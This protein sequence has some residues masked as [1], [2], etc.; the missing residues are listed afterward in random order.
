MDGEGTANLE[1]VVREGLLEFVTIKNYNEEVNCTNNWGKRIS[2][3]EN[4]HS[5][6]HH[7]FHMQ[8]ISRA[9]QCSR[10][11]GYCDKQDEFPISKIISHWNANKQGEHSLISLQLQIADHLPYVIC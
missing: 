9:R 2:N 5:F 6:I 1:E 4:K 10:P 7:S 3:R 8:N 11:Q